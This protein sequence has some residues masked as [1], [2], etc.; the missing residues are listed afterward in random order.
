MFSDRFTNVSMHEMGFSVFS[1]AATTKTKA[2]ECPENI[3]SP[4]PLFLPP[5]ATVPIPI[6]ESLPLPDIEEVWGENSRWEGWKMQRYWDEEALKNSIRASDPAQLYPLIKKLQ[7]NEPIVVVGVGS[8]IVADFGGLF[9]RDLETIYGLVPNPANRYYDFAAADRALSA[10]SAPYHRGWL[11]LF[12]QY[13]NHTWPHS[14]HILI[15]SGV[16]ARTPAVL[17]EGSCLEAVFPRQADL[18]VIE[19]MGVGDAKGLEQLSWR[20]LRHFQEQRADRP[21]IVYFNS[22]DVDAS[23]SREHYWTASCGAPINDA[24]W[25]ECCTNF[26]AGAV[27]KSFTSSGN[28][29]PWDGAHH[30]LARLYGFGSIS[31]RDFL[32]P[33]IKAKAW[34]WLTPNHGACGF[35]ALTNGDSIHPSHF[36]KVLFADY[37]WTYLNIGKVAY[38]RRHALHYLKSTT[39]QTSS[40]MNNTSEAPSTQ[41]IL[42]ERF[43]KAQ[44]PLIDSLSGSNIDRFP[45][46]TNPFS[47]EGRNVFFTRCYGFFQNFHRSS[48]LKGTSMELNIIKSIGFEF[49]ENTTHGTTA[50]RKPGWIAMDVGAFLEIEVDTLFDEIETP[51]PTKTL[52]NTEN[53]NTIAGPEIVLTFLKSYE[54]MGRANVTC[55]S[56]CCCEESSIEA[57]HE[58]KTSIAGM[59]VFSVTQSKNCRF[60]VLVT[61]GTSSGEHKF[62]VTQ[63]TTRMKLAQEVQNQ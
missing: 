32:Y 12:M 31:H 49:H 61:E 10:P 38:T 39:Q 62:K 35:I 59:H 36:G 7:N 2:K 63:V 40:D 56:G 51:E 1:C 33:Y 5:D 17:A 44:L 26:T 23:S 25:T 37:L 54:H 52:N 22:V 24:R 11:E 50:K 48:G 3:E 4:P 9:H 55:S 43:N 21:A 58:D 16:A 30:D 28:V 8:S 45:L 15:N 46:P 34:E 29:R 6:L 13:I 18:I 19:D 42:D 47:P 57:H 41:E 20:I 27:E 53:S 14:E 60:T